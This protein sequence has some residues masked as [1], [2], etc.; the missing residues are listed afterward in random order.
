MGNFFPLS[1]SLFAVGLVRNAGETLFT[2]PSILNSNFVLHSAP[3]RSQPY[4]LH[5]NYF[6]SLVH[7]MIWISNQ[8]VPIIHGSEASGNWSP[9]NLECETL[10]TSSLH[11]G[12]DLLQIT[13]KD[14]GRLFR[15]GHKPENW[16]FVMICGKM[17]SLNWVM[18]PTATLSRRES[19]DKRNDR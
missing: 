15:D 19:R 16:W 4:C 5:S 6:Q 1:L 10:K 12:N 9:N 8:T 11:E 13:N 7:L 3:N 17:E 18:N 14:L 2:E